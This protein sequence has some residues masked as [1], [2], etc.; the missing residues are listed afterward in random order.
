MGSIILN[1]ITRS[2][3]TV[4]INTFVNKISPNVQ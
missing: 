3:E 4:I 1:S 2:N